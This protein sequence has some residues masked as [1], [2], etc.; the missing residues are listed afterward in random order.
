[1]CQHPLLTV[2]RAI[3]TSFLQLTSAAYDDLVL[4]QIVEQKRSDVAA[5]LTD[6]KVNAKL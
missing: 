2:R 3:G 5:L 1:M 6:L 4:L